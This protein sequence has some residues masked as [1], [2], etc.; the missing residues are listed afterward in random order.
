MGICHIT[1]YTSSHMQVPQEIAMNILK[2]FL[3]IT[4]G[5]LPPFII[6]ILNRQ[7][8]S[9]KG[10]EWGTGIVPDVFRTCPI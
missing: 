2:D 7:S 6:Y 4:F 5:I 10:V 9:Y 1:K 3:S 8:V